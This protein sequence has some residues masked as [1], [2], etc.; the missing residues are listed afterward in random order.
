MDE[1]ARADACV[2][3]GECEAACPQNLEIISLLEDAH[4]QFETAG[5]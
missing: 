2:A 1:N 3:C 4:E 5:A